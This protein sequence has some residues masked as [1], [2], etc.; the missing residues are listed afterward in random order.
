MSLW[1]N[2][3][4]KEIECAR[5]Q[6]NSNWIE[7]KKSI[8]RKSFSLHMIL[9]ERKLFQFDFVQVS[10]WSKLLPCHN[11][12]VLNLNSLSLSFREEIQWGKKKDWKSYQIPFIWSIPFVLDPTSFHSPFHNNCSHFPLSLSLSLF[13]LSPSLS[14]FIH[15]LAISS[16]SNECV[17]WS[18][19]S[20]IGFWWNFVTQKCFVKN[21]KIEILEKKTLSLQEDNFAKIYSWWL[22]T[23]S[24]MLWME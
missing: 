8:G 23:Q 7:L 5:K 19:F 13:F 4:W 9:D 6:F 18:H 24:S 22:I 3:N 17:Y 2:V 15:Y 20:Q 12:I 11:L 1:V 21:K 10:F 16:L 14:L